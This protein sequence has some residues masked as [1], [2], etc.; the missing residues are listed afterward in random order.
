MTIVSQTHETS[1][2]LDRTAGRLIRSAEI[3]ARTNQPRVFAQCIDAALKEC[4]NHSRVIRGERRALAYK[5]QANNPFALAMLRVG[6]GMEDVR[7]Q[8]DGF[9]YDEPVKKDLAIA[10]RSI[11]AKWWP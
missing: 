6:H 11:S 8:M 9:R 7:R 4:A 1:T 2:D 5:A 10:G 3:A